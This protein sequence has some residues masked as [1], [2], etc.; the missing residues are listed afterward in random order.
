MISAAS[1]VAVET[2]TLPGPILGSIRV[3]RASRLRETRTRHSRPGIEQQGFDE[4][5]GAGRAIAGSKLQESQVH[6]GCAFSRV[7]LEG[8]PKRDSRVLLPSERAVDIANQRVGRDVAGVG[9]SRLARKHERLIEM[10]GEKFRDGCVVV[11]RRGLGLKLGQSADPIGQ[12][13]GIPQVGKTRREL[14]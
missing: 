5:I 13:V 6:I 9:R 1:V 2:A 7:E 12:P 8:Q 11:R 14:Q 3:D 10:A 4:V